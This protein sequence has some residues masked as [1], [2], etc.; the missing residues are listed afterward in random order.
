MNK[1]TEDYIKKYHIELMEDDFYHYIDGSTDH[2]FDDDELEVLVEYDLEPDTEI[3]LLAISTETDPLKVDSFDT[4]LH[5]MYYYVWH[6]LH[7]CEGLDE[8][9]REWLLTK[10]D[11]YEKDYTEY[12]DK[13]KGRILEE[14]RCAEA[15]THFEDYMNRPQTTPCDFEDYNGNHSCPFDAQGGDDCRN[16]CGL[17]VDE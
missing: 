1:R 17:G 12:C 16:F 2:Y 10:I 13:V 4:G 6:L 14:M 9:A 5:N 8:Q 7:K 11:I 15:G 3:N